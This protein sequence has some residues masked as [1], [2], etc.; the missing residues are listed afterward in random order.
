MPLT[1]AM[2]SAAKA[3]AALGLAAVGWFASEAIR[4]LLSEHTDFGWFNQVN[5]VLGFLCGW[6]VTGRR[7]GTNFTEAVSAGLTGSA[8]LTFWGLFAQAFNQML[9]NALEK[10]YDDPLEG[11]IGMFNLALEFGVYLLDGTVIAIL[12]IGGIVTG[13]VANSVANRV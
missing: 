4:P 3:V 13:L 5:V 11:I 1:D 8:A 9:D 12:I 10:K 7:V 2:P 6:R